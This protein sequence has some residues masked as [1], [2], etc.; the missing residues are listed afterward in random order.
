MDKKDIAKRTNYLVFAVVLAYLV[1]QL[2]SEFVLGMEW[3]EKNIYFVLAFI[4]LFVILLPILLF[5]RKH[6]MDWS[7]VFRIKPVTIP[8]MMLIVPMAVLSGI[9]AAI[10]NSIPVY[11]LG[12]DYSVP[13]G[14]VPVPSDIQE[15]I[16]QIIV[17]ALIPSVCEEVF[18]RGIIYHAFAGMGEWKAIIVSAFYFSLF[19]FDIRNLLGPFFLGILIAWYCY[20]TDS[21][22]AGI[23]AHF[24]NNFMLIMIN[25]FSE[26]AANEPL[27]LTPPI[28]RAMI[29]L[30]VFVG[31][32]LMILIKAFTTLTR[33]RVVKASEKNSG[34][35]SVITQWPMCFFYGIYIVITVLLLVK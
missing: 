33:N 9:I 27:N 11:L 12:K 20:R 16:V 25:F 6:K 26:S 28:I 23:I 34:L 15:L 19:H 32:V 1:L 18:F 35:L 8:E 22:F 7:S 14:G 17:V 13:T 29:T 30:T 10:L 2:F 3:I 5:V 31:I 21:I 4:Q 24:T